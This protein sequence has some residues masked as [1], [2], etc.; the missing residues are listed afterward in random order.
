MARMSE[1]HES[2][3]RLPAN[4]RDVLVCDGSRMRVARYE[5]GSWIEPA[6]HYVQFLVAHWT[7]LPNP[8]RDLA[9]MH[10][11]QLEQS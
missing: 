7:E 4:V 8:P 5:G 6:G 3:Y 11:V 10:A 1:W 2:K 9:V